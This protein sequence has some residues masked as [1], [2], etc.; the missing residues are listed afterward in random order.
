MLPKC[1]YLKEDGTCWFLFDVICSLEPGCVKE[2]NT[3]LP[4][5]AF[6]PKG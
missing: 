3:T 2:K 1:D 4:R 5:G 6:C